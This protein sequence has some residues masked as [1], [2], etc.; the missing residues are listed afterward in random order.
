MFVSNT[1]MRVNGRSGEF[2]YSTVNDSLYHRFNSEHPWTK[3]CG[4]DCR[5]AYCIVKQKAYLTFHTI[6]DG[7]VD[8]RPDT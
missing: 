7:A 6:G 5:A 3:V 8:P 4:S 2:F 1:L